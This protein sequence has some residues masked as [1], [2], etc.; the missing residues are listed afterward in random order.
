MRQLLLRERVP[1]EA[2]LARLEMDETVW[3][4]G[5]ARV[6]RMP[7][8][9]PLVAF[10]RHYYG[11]SA[12]MLLTPALLPDLLDDLDGLLQDPGLP[13]AMTAFLSGM[14]ALCERAL[15]AARS[16]TLAVIAD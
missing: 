4:D 5:H 10:W 12:E 8:Q 14:R 2:I 13:P 7:P 6:M 15:H 16:A 11:S 9:R 3:E 1:P